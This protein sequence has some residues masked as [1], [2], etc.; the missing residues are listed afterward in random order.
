MKERHKKDMKERNQNT[1][2]G[3]SKEGEFNS[4]KKDQ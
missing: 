2:L 4:T 1:K 3:L